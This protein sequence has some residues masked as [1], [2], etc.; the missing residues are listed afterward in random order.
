MSY[1]IAVLILFSGVILKTSAAAVEN[2]NE[3]A[4]G[5]DAKS[6][7]SS[8]AGNLM[9]RGYGTTGTGGSQVV[10]LNLTNLLVLVLLKA[11]IFAA[12]SLGAGTWK[13]GFG[14]SNDGDEQFLTEEEILLFLSYLTGSPGDN[15]CLQNVSCRQ[16]QQA[17]RY[18]AAGDVLLKATQ[19]LSVDPDRSYQYVL[20]EVEQAAD[21]GL[22]G[23][24]CARF[25]N[26]GK[27][28][29]IQH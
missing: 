2:D 12:G 29:L 15:G 7:L 22:A 23:G 6:L 24:D 28:N 25:S 27:R 21:I 5:L 26:I 20:K 16:P 13:G 3:I 8:I 9:S 17:K 14:R 18:V 10:S 11:L 19:M 4:R 1:K